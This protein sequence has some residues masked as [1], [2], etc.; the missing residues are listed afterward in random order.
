M[1]D[2]LG[3][4]FAFFLTP[5]QAHDL[6]GADALLPQMKADTVLADKAFDADERVIESLLSTKNCTKHT[7]S[8]RIS[9]AS[10][11]N[12]VPSPLVMTRRPETFSPPFI[13]WPRRSCSI[14]D[15]PYVGGPRR[16]PS[17][18]KIAF[19]DGQRDHDMT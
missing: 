11:S 16:P 14:E 8:S 6:E 3:N 1:V 10:L 18:P 2:A 7:I 19:D 15:T 4:P 13:W 12:S 17:W 5:G 9:S